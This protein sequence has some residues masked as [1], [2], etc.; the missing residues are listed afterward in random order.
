MGGL[1]LTLEELVRAYTVLSDGGILSP[2]RW[3]ESQPL[4]EPVRIFSEET[5][6]QI[7]LFLSDPQARLPSFPRMGN[8]E[9]RFPVAVKTGISNG[10]L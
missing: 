3:Y 6:R 4:A 1:P 8:H 10:V 7:S 9:Y 5:A 2:L